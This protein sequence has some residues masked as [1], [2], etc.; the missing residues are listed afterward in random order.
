MFDY[1]TQEKNNMNFL[2]GDHKYC[3][4]VLQPN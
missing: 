2:T 1:F 4:Y 3:T